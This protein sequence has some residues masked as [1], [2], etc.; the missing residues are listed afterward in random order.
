MSQEKII[1]ILKDKRNKESWFTAREIAGKLRIAVS[2]ATVSL[3]K[4]REARL[5]R[6]KVERNLM[7]NVEIFKYKYKIT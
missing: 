1:K 5:I 7:A 2:S 6:F 4:L 3:K